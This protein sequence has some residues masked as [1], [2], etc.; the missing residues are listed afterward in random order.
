MAGMVGR[1]APLLTQAQ[2]D[3]TVEENVEHFNIW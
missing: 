2:F 1:D 3:A